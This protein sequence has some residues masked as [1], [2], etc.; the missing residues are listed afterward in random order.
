MSQESLNGLAINIAHRNIDGPQSLR[1][2][3]GRRSSSDG[4]V[5]EGEGGKPKRAGEM[6]PNEGLHNSL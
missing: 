4:D 3:Y 5:P 6:Y 2:A 1:D